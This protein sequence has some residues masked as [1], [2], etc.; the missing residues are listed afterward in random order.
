MTAALTFARIQLSRHLRSPA[1]WFVALAAP[2]AARFMVPAENSG[3]TVVAINN[4]YPALTAGVIGL[5]LGII[6]GL[7]LS[8][9]AY[10]FLR[11]GPTRHQPWQVEDVTPKSRA[12]QYF[13]YW[14]AD[15][16]VLWLV[17]LGLGMAGILLSF[18]RLAASDVNPL[19]TLSALFLIAGP[20]MAFIAAIR[21][22]FS[23]RPKL[24]GGLGD[25]L[26][27]ILWMFGISMGALFFQSQSISMFFD[28]FGY[29]A[30]LSGAVNVPVETFVVGSAPSVSGVI[31][32]DAMQ[33]VLAPEFITSRLFWFFIAAAT[34]CFAGAIYKGRI[35]KVT[36]KNRG[37]R[38]LLVSNMCG[39][40]L[41][42]II[43]K[44][45]NV[46]A[47]LWTHMTQIISPNG[48]LLG[49]V[50]AG[51]IGAFLP[52]RGG[53][54][55]IIWLLLIFP[56]TAHSG[57]WRSQNISQFL[58]TMPRSAL[59]QFAWCNLAAIILSVFVCVPAFIR[60]LALGT[61]EIADIVFVSFA[62]P[63][64]IMTLGYAARSG[65]AA[66]LLMLCLW[67]GYLNI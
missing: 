58:Q 32:L 66:R 3:Y 57:R 48:W 15:T 25:V 62:V 9:L 5:E 56:L 63:V 1:L 12:A 51:A 22:V 31:E 26:F 4:A 37:K 35:P 33:G 61:G 39:A 17:L 6:T 7:L 13:G 21:L 34:A 19:E 53:A 18:F 67:Y 41:D 24:A 64:I 36:V 29:A 54:G 30:S 60:M 55:V 50:G 23:A 42:Q 2:I 52:F 43:P 11:S 28:V 20:V 27:F 14:L 44:K 16:A 8:P 59:E 10:I 65:F 45:G 49:F 40:V 47:L 38:L 46:L